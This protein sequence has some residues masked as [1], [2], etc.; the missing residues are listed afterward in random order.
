MN[1]DYSKRP[2]S[3]EVSLS[4]EKHVSLIGDIES[5]FR[6]ENDEDKTADY[7][8]QQMTLL[9]NLGIVTVADMAIYIKYIAYL[10]SCYQQM[11][12]EL[13]EKIAAHFVKNPSGE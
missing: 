7:L 12:D 2:L 8:I 4:V 6:N 10:Q 9:H 1:I 11:R 13:N 3:T 5:L